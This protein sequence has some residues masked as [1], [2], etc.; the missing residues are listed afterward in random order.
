MKAIDLFRCMLCKNCNCFEEDHT[1]CQKYN[2]I[3]KEWSNDCDTCGFSKYKHSTCENFVTID[4]KDRCD[5]C[6]K[7]LID[8]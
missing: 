4:C 6:G 5:N 2:T 8:H 7:D 1:I 3:K